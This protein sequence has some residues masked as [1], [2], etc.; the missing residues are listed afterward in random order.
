MAQPLDCVVVESLGCSWLPAPPPE[1]PDEPDDPEDPEDPEEPLEAPDDP[2][3]PEEPEELD[4][5]PHAPSDPHTEPAA[6]PLQSAFDV[7]P[8]QLPSPAHSGVGLE[9]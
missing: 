8:A 7:Q 6:F 5:L 9:H 3:D 1:A 4:P 2:D